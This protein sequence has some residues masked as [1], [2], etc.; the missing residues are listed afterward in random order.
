MPQ[1]IEDYAM[2]GDAHTAALV[3]MDGSIDWLCLPRFDSASCFAALLGTPQHGRWLLAP[4]GGASGTRRRYVGDTLVLETDHTTPSGVVRVTD[5]MPRRPNRVEGNPDLVRLVEGVSGTVDMAMELVVRFDYGSI[6]P[7]VRREG[8]GD[9]AFIGGP[10]SLVLRTPVRTEGHD[11]TTVARFRVGAGD[12]VPFSLTWHRSFDPG[13]EPVDVEQ[14]I[15]ETIEHWEAWAPAKGW[16]GSHA[17]A[18]R[19]SVVVLKALTYE[20]SGG[21]VAAV[22]TSLPEEIGGVR[23]WDYR[24]CWLRDA[25]VTLDALMAAGHVAEGAAFRQWLLRAAA[26]RPSD[27]QVLYGVRGERRL[28][29]F[30]VPWLPGHHGSAPVRVGNGAHTQLQLDV[31]GEVLNTLA[32]ARE[33]GLDG[34]VD[35]QAFEA[36]ILG[37]LEEHWQQPDEGVWEVRGPR[38]HFTHSKILVWVAFDRAAD[39]AAKVGDREAERRW[40]AAADEVHAEVMAR[41]VDPE[42]GHLQQSYGSKLVDAACLVAPLYGFLPADHPVAV[43]TVDAVEHRLLDGGLVRRYEA[44]GSVDG[45]PEG[46]GAFLPCS[47]WLVDN[48]LCQGRRDEGGVLL[49]RILDLRNDVGLLAE[50][51]DPATGRFLGN[52]PQ[53]WSHVALVNTVTR[54]GGPARARQALAEP[55]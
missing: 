28:S 51:V 25:S 3:G 46:E 10:D 36:S 30:E 20:P 8:D 4:E 12:K 48:L 14:A 44:D 49:E 29:E 23:N 11:L 55:T 43:A 16:T 39:L 26:G 47:F 33:L 42:G 41:A 18:V 53:A 52:F 1:R 40:R 54:F 22:T 9:L 24:Y 27:V 37:W 31:Y 15:A 13:P 32:K 34:D 21:M 50:E 17:D 2:V 7:W 45:L 5:C 38:R 19:R 35:T 6:V